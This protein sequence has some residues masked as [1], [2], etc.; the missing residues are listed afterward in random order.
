MKGQ[1][2]QSKKSKRNQ[3]TKEIRIDLDDLTSKT[4]KKIFFCGLQR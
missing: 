4:K 2:Y 3:N 1:K